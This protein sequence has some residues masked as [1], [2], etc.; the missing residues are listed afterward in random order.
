[1]PKTRYILIANQKGGVGKTTIADE[2]AFALERRGFNVAFQNLDNQGGCIHKSTIIDDDADFVVID[3]PG[4][5]NP[6]FRKWCKAADVVVIPSKPSMQDFPAFN[7]TWTIA[8]EVADASGEGRLKVGCVVNFFD[9]RRKVDN[10]WLEFLGNASYPVFA[11]VPEATVFANAVAM[12]ES[13][14]DQQPT[15]KAAKAI[16]GLA[17]RILLEVGNV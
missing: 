4:A 17:D 14:Y 12:Q 1:M 2:L 10:Q 7:R 15:G 3:T 11:V 5:I 9:S 16:E 13:V 6:D 8:S